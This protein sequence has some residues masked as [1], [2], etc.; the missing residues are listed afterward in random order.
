[1]IPEGESPSGVPRASFSDLV[2]V[3]G[4]PDVSLS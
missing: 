1:V 3:V 2:F 4:S